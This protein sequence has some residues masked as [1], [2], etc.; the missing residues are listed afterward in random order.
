MI[1][2]TPQKAFKRSLALTRLHDK[3]SS[4]CNST[5]NETEIYLDLFYSIYIHVACFVKILHELFFFMDDNKGFCRS[6]CL[7]VTHV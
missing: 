1:A 4:D 3:A 5:D 6:T 7:R 2:G